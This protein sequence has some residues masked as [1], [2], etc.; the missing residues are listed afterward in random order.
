MKNLSMKVALIA[1]AS[2]SSTLALA[3][4]VGRVISSTP[5]VQQVAVAREV[6]SVEQ[7]GVQRPRSGAGAV[8]GALAGGAMGNAM[9]DGS[10]RAAATII[11]LI[12]GAM[13]GD[14]IENSDPYAQQPMRQCTTQQFYE[15]RTTAYSVVYEYAGKQYNVQLPYDPG[16][17]IQLQVRPV[18]VGTANVE[19][20]YVQLPARVVLTAP[21]YAPVY[22]AYVVR[23]YYHPPISLNFGFGY[24]GGYRHRHWR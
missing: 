19:P 10:G 17:T 16:P 2:L 14:R 4:E 13:V 24:S 21:T 8:M 12:G 7:V 23:P 20:N 22:P 1:A 5:I 3:Q 6:C 9:G 18:G 15:P 11:G